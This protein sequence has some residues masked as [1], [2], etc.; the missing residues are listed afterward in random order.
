[1]SQI[2]N[3]TNSITSDCGQYVCDLTPAISLVTLTAHTSSERWT[4]NIGDALSNDV[5]EYNINLSCKLKNYPVVTFNHQFELIIN[6]SLGST[7]YDFIFTPKDKVYIINNQLVHF[8]LD[9]IVLIPP[10]SDCNFEY[11][12]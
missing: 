3:I 10:V 8:S 5:G 2:F 7:F 4:I 6:E 9:P 11:Q 12:S 1:M